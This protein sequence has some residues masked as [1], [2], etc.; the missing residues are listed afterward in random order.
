MDFFM[1]IVLSIPL[2]Q[3]NYSTTE[4]K[5]KAKSDLLKLFDDG[6]PVFSGVGGADRGKRRIDRQRPREWPGIFRS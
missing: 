5:T 6:I 1:L 2:F 4:Y 3:K